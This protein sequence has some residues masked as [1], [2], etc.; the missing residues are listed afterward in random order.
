MKILHYA[1]GFPPYRSG[2]LTK[3][4]VDLMFSQKEEGHNVAMMWPGEFSFAGHFVRVKKSKKAI[5]DDGKNI[6][7]TSFEIINPLPVPLDE[8]ITEI[9]AYTQQCPN[10]E[11]FSAFLEN[12]KPDVIHLHTLMGLHKE[13]L[14]KA[15]EQGIRVVFTSHD[16]FG[17]CPKVTLFRNG[18]VCEGNCANCAACN[19]DALSIRKIKILQS[20]LYRNLKDSMLVKK[21]RA[22]HRQQFFEEKEQEPQHE[23][24]RGATHYE[25]AE[26]QEA[27][28]GYEKLRNYYIDM[29]KLVGM[30]HFNS[31]VTEQ[32]YRKF[33][34]E[35]IQGKVINISHKNIRDCRKIKTYDKTLKITYLA[36]AKPFKGYAIL[37]QALD[38][39]WNEGLR[40][41]ELN[42]YGSVGN[43]SEY[44]RVH[45]RFQYH[46][47]EEIFDQTDLLVAPSVWYETFG[48]TVLEALSFGVP[49]LV[50][51]NVGAKD[52][53]E[54]GKYGVICKPTKDE[55]KREIKKVIESRNGLVEYNKR[56]V[57][58]MDLT[59]VIE[60]NKQISDLYS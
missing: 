28:L 47:L 6:T 33:L 59:T 11:V 4:C 3:Y 7:V 41:F 12:Y 2:G 57:E 18:E 22:R 40:N 5:G 51:T 53:L 14:E 9:E 52:L 32:V 36:P 15:Y 24:Q 50:S 35:E 45:D 44:M 10:P 55:V 60:S 8:G 27:A 13:F 43:T 16:Y 30:I 17:L 54:D 56:I 25:I 38:E 23:V 58:E 20:S 1:L 39:L 29:L 34:P 42:L 49:V 46:Q 31:T 48:F 19:Q 37:K 26:N 21:L